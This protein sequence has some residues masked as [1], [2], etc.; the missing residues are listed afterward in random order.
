MPSSKVEVLCPR[1]VR[2]RNVLRHS[3]AGR[4][5]DGVTQGTLSAARAWALVCITCNL[6]KA[7]DSH[8][9]A[10]IVLN[11]KIEERRMRGL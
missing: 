9:A 3:R 8:E 10:I 1:C 11:R 4:Q 2:V 6:L 7:R 5:Q